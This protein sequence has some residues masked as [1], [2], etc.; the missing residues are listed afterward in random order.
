LLKHGRALL[1]LTYQTLTFCL[2]LVFGLAALA[3]ARFCPTT[4]HH[5]HAAWWLTGAVFTVGG[6]LAVSQGFVAILAF[7]AGPGS[8]LWDEFVRWAPV[9]NQSR[10]LLKISFAGLIAILPFC[11]EKQIPTFYRA[12]AYSSVLA[13]T[14]GGWVGWRV[15]SLTISDQFIAIA[16]SNITLLI[17][18]G[19]GLLIH[20]AKDTMDRLLWMCLCIYG[21]RLALGALW[22]GASS[23]PYE[24]EVWR[25][26]VWMMM[27][28]PAVAYVIKLALAARFAVLQRR[29]VY[30]PALYESLRPPKMRVFGD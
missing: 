12:A 25:P 2:S 17:V 3:I 28:L 11:R 24:L 22:A 1:V 29:K 26:P 13:L 21:F 18:L 30:V 14:L 16:T 4:A 10:S 20:L 23:Y 19:F 15:G 27:A 7:S 8:A 6:T 9:G 5:R